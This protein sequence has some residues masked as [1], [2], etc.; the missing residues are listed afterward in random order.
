MTETLW[1]SLSLFLAKSDIDIEKYEGT[2][3]DS[4]KT[5][6]YTSFPPIKEQ[7]SQTMEKVEGSVSKET[8]ELLQWEVKH[9]ASKDF[10]RVK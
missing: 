2:F 1:P 6:A 3:C 5:L 4:Y 8:S 7:N 9:L 10:I